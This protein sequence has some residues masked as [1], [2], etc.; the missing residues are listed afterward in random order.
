MVREYVFSPVNVPLLTPQAAAR[1]VRLA[2]QHAGEDVLRISVTLDIGLSWSNALLKPAA[3]E[4]VLPDAGVTLPLKA[5]EEVASSTAVHVLI[6]GELRP[7]MLYDSEK[8]RHYK[9]R[10]LGEDVAP[11]LE[12]N[13]IHMHRIEGVDPIRDSIA[14]VR[15]LG[16]LRKALVLDVCTGLG[17]TASLELRGGAATVITVEVDENVLNLARYNPWSRGLRSAKILLGDATEVIRELEDGS[18]TH[19]LHDPPRFALAGHLYSL[20]FYRELYRVLKP[21]GK[22]FHY[23]GSPG[24][25]RGISFAKGVKERLR[26]AGFEHIRWVEGAQG[27][28]ALKPRW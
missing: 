13:G 15:A 27:F 26:A 24:R 21:G 16:R 1:I 22:I 18:F 28:A 12:I 8:R 25:R 23:V 4:V 10:S 7:L 9:L 2:A 17:Y 5:L 6:N 20:E 11:T 19:V 14:K 3:G